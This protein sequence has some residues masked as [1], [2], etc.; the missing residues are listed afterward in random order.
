TQIRILVE[1]L[2]EAVLL[3]ACGAVV[4]MLPAGVLLVVLGV[5][6]IS[7]SISPMLFLRLLLF[8]VVVGAVFGV[9]PAYKASKL[10]PVEALRSE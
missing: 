9:Y 5:S 3:S 8:S 6:G 4:G 2:I 7:V 10:Q 1:F